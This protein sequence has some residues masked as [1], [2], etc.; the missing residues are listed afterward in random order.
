MAALLPQ[1]PYKLLQKR[2]DE[3]DV[4]YWREIRALYEGGKALLRNPEVFEKL[5]PRHA[6]EPL[7]IYEERKRRAYYVNHLATVIDQLVAGLACDE[8]KMI[9]PGGTSATPDA[10]YSAYLADCSKPGGDRQSF[11][12]LMLDQ[13]KTALLLGRCWT[14]DDLPVAP[15]D[16]TLDSE[17]AQ[18][19]AGLLNVYSAAIPPE[20]VLDWDE[21]GDGKLAWVKTCFT[22]RR[23]LD[24]F[25]AK[26]TTRE[27][28]TFY[29]PDRW[30][31][32]VVEYIEG[33]EDKKQ[34]QQEDL[35]TAAAA[36]EHS[37]GRVPV[38]RLVLPPGVWAGNKIHSLAVE[39]LNKSCGLSWAEYRSL[40]AQLY[41]FLGTEVA[42]VDS[43]INEHQSNP[44]RA[45]GP[46]GVGYVQVR[47]QDDSAEYVSPPADAFAHSAESIKRLEEAM[48]RITY[49]IALAEDNSGA[50]IRRSAE[51]KQLDH[52]VTKVAV[53][54]IGKRING[55]AC[56]VVDTA[57]VGRGDLKP[58]ESGWTATGFEGYEA[59]DV[60]TLIDQSVSLEA[61]SV[62]SATY[63]RAR[64]LRLAKADLGQDATPEMVASIEEELKQAITQDQLAVAQIPPPAPA[65]GEDVVPGG[66]GD[67]QP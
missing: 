5:F 60:G 66:P 26:V 44:N 19:K 61:V 24:P 2:H 34:P 1:I 55:H 11:M 47:G 16:E 7:K 53:Q 4:E 27:E 18:R 23:Q 17:A 67:R 51:S 13:A 22:T 20:C 49:Q 62:P 41:E 28:Y 32:W 29:F 9:P 35:V 37:F 43:P 36:A 58:G 25:S 64:K 50:V 6:G 57:A 21:G 63:Q 12:D 10:F 48:F 52:A 15:A 31:R 54:A 42:G 40:F 65:D 56:L 33:S 59:A 39:Y 8:L 30:A 14:I 45:E 3:C 38:I 46:R